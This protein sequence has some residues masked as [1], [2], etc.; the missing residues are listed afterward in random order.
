MENLWRAPTAN[1]IGEN[2]RTGSYAVS[3]LTSGGGFTTVSGL[4]SSPV[5]TAPEPSSLWLLSSGAI[6]ILALARTTGRL[7]M[8]RSR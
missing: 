1:L 5:S 3:P 6:G 8:R 4:T 2:S 7:R